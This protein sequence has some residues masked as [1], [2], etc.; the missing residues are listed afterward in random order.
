VVE[1]YFRLRHYYLRDKKFDTFQA[2]IQQIKIVKPGSSIV[3]S[4]F[5]RHNPR[6]GPLD[7]T[8]VTVTNGGDKEDVRTEK[9][10]RSDK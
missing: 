3:A 1:V 7:I 10:Q 9:R 8:K 6:E 2:E 5:Q 4:G